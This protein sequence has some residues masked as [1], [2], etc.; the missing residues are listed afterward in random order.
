[1]KDSWDYRLR[2]SWHTIKDLSSLDWLTKLI[3]RTKWLS[4]GEASVQT[5]SS[6][7]QLSGKAVYFLREMADRRLKVLPNAG[8]KCSFPE[9]RLVCGPRSDQKGTWWAESSV[10]CI[11][12]HI[13]PN[14]CS[15]CSCHWGPFGYKAACTFPLRMALLVSLG[16]FPGYSLISN[17]QCNFSLG[18][19]GCLFF[20]IDNSMIIEYC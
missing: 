12:N 10:N 6:C 11:V 3:Y 20:M 19:C 8:R 9:G 15:K 4:K 18:S 13:R 1:M 16:L 14:S 7:R 5:F 2:F 17:A